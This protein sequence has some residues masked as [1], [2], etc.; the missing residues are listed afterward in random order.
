MP[1]VR[2]IGLLATCRSEGG[3]GEIHAISDAALAFRDGTVTWVGAERDLPASAG[4][5][6]TWDAGGALM[7]PGLIDCHTHLAFGGWRA[8]EFVRR[9]RGESYAEIAA[10]GGG[11]AATV[12]R[13]RAL[14]E[15]ALLER[16]RGFAARMV[17]LGVTCVE[18]KSGYGL[19]RETELRLLRVYRALDASGPV[20]VVPTYLGAHV[21]PRD[22]PRADY[23]ALV[24]EMIG[25]VARQGLARFCDVFVEQGAFSVDEARRLFVA[26]RAAGLLPKVHADQ[27]TDTGAAALAAEVGAISAD[28]LEHVG[29]T[30]IAALARAG[31]VAVS[32]PLAAL[33]LDQPSLPARAL[34][35][36]GV[37][38][39]VASDFNPGSAPSAHLPLALTLAC[40]RQ[41]L[42]PAEALKGATLH[43][44]RAVA[45]ERERGSL[46][47]GKSASFALID[48]PDV[49]HWLYHFEANACLL[50]VV[51]GRV[52]ARAPDFRT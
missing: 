2:H 47:P 26:A 15:D 23:V 27:L 16:S 4:D 1:V 7:I 10:A 8:D 38:V 20:R 33:Y 51:D 19:D 6:E 12:A 22:Q 37:A 3:Q 13:T 34:I 49:E 41:R 50:T 46:E 44:A 24:E 9:L 32:L 17:A 25:E 40:V 52:R 43:A 48:A 28:H 21:V 35:D 39:A 30:G 29:P 31:V 36:A 18:A 45:L 11:I 42:T 14:G 5:G